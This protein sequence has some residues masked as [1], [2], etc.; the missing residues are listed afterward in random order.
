M[1]RV[2]WTDGIVL[3]AAAWLGGA[4][5]FAQPATTSQPTSRPALPP[6]AAAITA[7]VLE[8]RGDC[9]HAAVGSDAWQPCKVGDEYAQDTQIM[10]GVRSS[11]KLRVGKDDTHTAMVIEPATKTLIREAHATNDTKKVRIGV[12]YGRIRAGVVEGGLKSDF[13]VESPVAT[14]SKRGTWNFGLAY[15]RG[16]ERFEIFLL[17][18][19]LVEAFH[20][21]TGTRR[22]VLPGTL[23][24]EVMRRWLDESQMQRNVPIPDLFGQGDIEVAFNRLQQ[25]GLRIIGPEG[26]ASVLLDLSSYAAQREFAGL[27]RRGLGTLPTL[28]AAGSRLHAEGVFGTGRGEQLVPL[29]VGD[30]SILAQ[31]GL[32]RPG[33][34]RFTRSALENWLRNR[35]Q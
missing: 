30:D 18:Q 14:L 2:R 16:T 35:R 22:H 20:K 17:D 25:D 8:V 29:I 13:T 33:T 11:L 7:E 1:K 9:Q 32:A 15:E 10:T 19:G 5:L 21:A 27:A 26:G 3:M 6:G 24:S 31:K 28:G 23:V 4:T 12:G 34:Y